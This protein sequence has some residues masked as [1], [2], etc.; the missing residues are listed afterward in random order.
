MAAFFE[1]PVPTR[2]MAFSRVDFP[3]LGIPTTSIL[4]PIMLSAVAAV[5]IVFMSFLL[6]YLMVGSSAL[7]IAW[8]RSGK[9][10]GK[11]P[12]A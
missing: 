5:P 10:E 2:R 1:F 7:G 3:T 8:E 4:D 12:L 9:K 6:F 11:L